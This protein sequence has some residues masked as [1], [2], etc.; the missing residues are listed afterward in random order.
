MRI[1][2]V[3]N[4]RN[5]GQESMQR[6]AALLAKG[7]R[8]RSHSVLVARPAA[9]AGR[10]RRSATG[11]GKWLGYIDKLAIFPGQLR[12][13]AS[14]AD[15]VHI[16]DHSNSFYV[17]AM[18]TKPHIITCH[19]LLEVMSSLGSIK[20]RRPKWTGRRLQRMIL[21]GL[22]R[23]QHI[24][25]VS[26]AT[27]RDLLALGGIEQED[28]SVIPSALN[29]PYSP[30]HP[31]AA[32]SRLHSLGIDEGKPYI[33][34]VGGNQWYK[35]RIGALR[36][37]RELK[38]R[39]PA[40]SL[41]MAGKP[42][43]PEMRRYVT[44]FG[45]GTAVH[46]RVAVSEEHL[47]ALYSRAELLLFPSIA[48]GFGWPVLEAQACGCPVA[49]SNREPL[50]EV[51]GGAAIYFDP[52]DPGGAA[53]L[54]ASGMCRLRELREMGLRNATQ[55]TLAKMI[56]G[57]LQVYAELAQTGVESVSTPKKPLAGRI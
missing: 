6:Y 45:L 40:L 52:A 54:I 12:A 30:M 46:E 28:T 14:Q 55:F 18:G 41:V 23:S 7:L 48:E 43:T 25:C 17:G 57:Y 22:R 56:D 1:L 35:N 53:A 3:A 9:L 2:L 32:G 16:C 49:T 10:L 31:I 21:N 15:V 47:R 26:N 29:Y 13:A 4:Y 19:D 5:D 24:A 11:V 37:F 38:A 42:W 34:H 20:G 27:R 8:D 39:V 50:T 33:L 51:S 44:E 36:I